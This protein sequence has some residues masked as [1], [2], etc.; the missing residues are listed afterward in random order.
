M[1]PGDAL[2]LKR[3]PFKELTA[4]VKGGEVVCIA[5]GPSLTEADVELVR[6]WRGEKRCV[7]V[8]N[9]SFRI[10]PWAD[11]MYAMDSGWWGVHK[12]EAL[13]FPGLKF[14]SCSKLLPDVKRLPLHSFNNFGN[15]GAAIVM[16]AQVCGAKAVYLLGYDCQFTN[17]KSHWHGDH[18]APLKNALSVDKWPQKFRNLSHVL[19]VKVVNCSRETALDAFPRASLEECLGRRSEVSGRVPA[20]CDE[21]AA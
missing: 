8:A 4:L 15:S 9:N 1:T 10:A 13:K 21:C 16:L 3:A 5:S 17:G 14:T 6:Q 7:F 18:A 19:R 11:A 2:S 12:K 20:A